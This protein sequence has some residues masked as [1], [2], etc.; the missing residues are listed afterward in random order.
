MAIKPHY[1]VEKSL[2]LRPP[3]KFSGGGNH[4]KR[5]VINRSKLTFPLEEN[6]RELTV[7]QDGVASIRDS[8]VVNGWLHDAYPPIAVSYTHLTLP[9]KA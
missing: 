5:I 1:D 7:L 6:S 4:I 3:K 9:T 2:T 8:F